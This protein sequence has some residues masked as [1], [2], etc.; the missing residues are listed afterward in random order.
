MLVVVVGISEA[1]SEPFEVSN[2]VNVGTESLEWRSLIGQE[3]VTSLA[4]VVVVKVVV[5][6]SGTVHGRKV[7]E[8]R[9]RVLASGL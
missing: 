7:R 5:T 2:I 8:V 4:L 3:I 1:I 6:S 9:V